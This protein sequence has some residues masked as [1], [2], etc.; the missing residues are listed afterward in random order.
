MSEKKDQKEA[1]K[2]LATDKLECLKE[3]SRIE[4]ATNEM[5]TETEELAKVGNKCLAFRK[6]WG[7]FPEAKKYLDKVEAIAEKVADASF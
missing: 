5:P 4:K 2:M 6:K 3:F 1:P 7:G